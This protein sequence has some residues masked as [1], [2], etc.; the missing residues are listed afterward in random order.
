MKDKII[1]LGI[2]KNKKNYIAFFSLSC[3]F[4]N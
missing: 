4:Y 2:K 1:F 3:S